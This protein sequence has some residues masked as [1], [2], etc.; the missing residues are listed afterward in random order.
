MTI[1][2]EAQMELFFGVEQAMIR[3]KSTDLTLKSIA[4][5]SFIHLTIGISFKI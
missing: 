4:I 2:T 3:L 5:A 1:M